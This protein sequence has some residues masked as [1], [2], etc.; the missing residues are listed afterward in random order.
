MTLFRPLLHVL[1]MLL[2]ML[3][4]ITS[5]MGKPARTYDVST[6]YEEQEVDRGVL[7]VKYAVVSDLLRKTHILV[8]NVVKGGPAD[9]AG[10][11]K[12][13]RIVIINGTPVVSL[14]P[15]QVAPLMRGDPGTTLKLAVKR[16]ADTRV[17]TLTRGSLTQLPDRGFQARL[18]K[19]VI[20]DEIDAAIHSLC[21]AAKTAYPDIAQAVQEEKYASAASALEFVTHSNPKTNTLVLYGLVLMKQGKQTEAIEILQRV[22]TPIE[23]KRTR[24]LVRNLLAEPAE[25]K[26]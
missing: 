9:S 4:T 23:D 14:K 11:R 21:T 3:C 15:K 7:G 26:H 20:N 17:L 10:L 8:T 1:I 25:I 18:Q 22:R 13:D 24:D 16:G 5:G 12:A 6:E 2:I 19:Q